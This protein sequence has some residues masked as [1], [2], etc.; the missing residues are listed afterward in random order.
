M[1]TRPDILIVGQGLAGTVLAWEFERAGFSFVIADGGVAPATSRMAAG[2]INPVTGQ[3]FAR[4]WKIDEWRGVAQACYQSMEAAWR[5]PLWQ[6]M[7]L[8]IQL[9]DTTARERLE[10]RQRAGQ[11]SPYLVELD[12]AGGGLAGAARVDFRAML[13]AA[14]A[15]WRAVG[16]YISE[17]RDPA[18]FVDQ[19]RLVIDCRGRAV[20]QRGVFSAVPWEISKG[21]ILAIAARGVAPDLII[22]SGPHWL[23][24]WGGDEVWI[25]ATHEPGVNDI[26]ASAG[27]RDRLAAV[28]AQLVPAPW[29]IVGQ[30]AGVR[31]HVPDRLPVVGRAASEPRLGILNALG[32]KGA[33]WAPALARQWVNHLADGVPFDAAVDVRRFQGS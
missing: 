13:D 11:L 28:A 8:R 15:H 23:L 5:R 33:L 18:D 10:A 2:M 1:P 31:V 21:E 29:R 12:A 30:N 24:P 6:E 14:A 9:M 22:H 32:G 7:R 19:Y 17:T 27:A 20:T 16:K 26:A 4:T 25:G 3:R